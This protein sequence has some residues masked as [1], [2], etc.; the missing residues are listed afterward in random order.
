MRQNRLR[1][2]L[3]QSS[4]TR[5]DDQILRRLDVGLSGGRP[6]YIGRASPGTQ[7]A[8]MQGSPRCGS[9]P[10]SRPATR[11]WPGAGKIARQ[12]R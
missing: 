6:G 3:A 4:A 11:R 5:D 8:Q 7:G 1:G 2:S 9:W 10:G 12:E